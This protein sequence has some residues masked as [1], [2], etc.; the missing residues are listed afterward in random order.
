MRLH[1]SL[2][3]VKSMQKDDE[4]TVFFPPAASPPGGRG[5]VFPS[6]R[7]RVVHVDDDALVVKLDGTTI[8][9][10]WDHIAGIQFAEDGKRQAT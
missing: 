8:G 6:W 2:G 9:L 1:R 5:A 3:V 10:S 4:I 7:V